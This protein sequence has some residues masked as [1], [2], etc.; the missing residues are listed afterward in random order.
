MSNIKLTIGIPS[1]PSRN[2][3]FLQPMYAKLMG[4]IGDYKDVEVLSIMDNKTMS[5]GRK[6]S[7][8]FRIAQG[9]YTCIIDDDDDVSMDFV[10]TLRAAITDDM[11]VDVISYDQ[12]S[13]IQG[14]N[15]L[16]RSSIK[17]NCEPPFDQLSVDQ[18][19]T[20]IPC[21]RPPWHWCCWRTDFARNIAFGDS[22]WGEDAVFV[23][24][25]AK[26]AKTELRIDKVMC[27]YRWSP[28]VSEAPYSKT[29]N[30]AVVLNL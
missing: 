3:M 24:T 30:K 4:Q 28:S 15:W 29:E 20:P 26:E 18:N 9:K 21:N 2:R 10:Q 22:N 11:N 16:I 25:A 6:R 1:I 5:I 14:K 8:L 13:E 7:L 17:H 12:D 23:A 19:G 27:K